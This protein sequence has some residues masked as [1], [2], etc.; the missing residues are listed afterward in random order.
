MAVWLIALLVAFVATVQ[1]RSQAEVE[2]SLQQADPATLAFSIDQLHRSNDQ[3]EAQIASLKQQQTML[4]T[5]GGDAVD[6]QLISEANQLR[7]LEGLVAV[8]GPGIVL[9]LDASG[10][11]SIDLQDAINNLSAGGGEALALNGH[12]IVLGVDIEQ[13]DIGVSVDGSL[14]NAPWRFDV[15]GD[16]SRLAE[17]AD[18]MTQQLRGDRRVLVA[19]YSVEQ[20]L[21]V[22]AVV[23]ERPFVYAV[24]S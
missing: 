13:S 22:R 20:D 15:I 17:T 18:L 23:T 8:H 7:M 5:G 3:L 14:V 6:Q 9:T 11:T 10:L 12:R 4:Q 21:V 24:S 1:L 19:A 16:P 2:R